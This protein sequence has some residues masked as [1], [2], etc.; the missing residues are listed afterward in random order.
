MMNL[1][2]RLWGMALT[3]KEEI[4]SDGW[5]LEELVYLYIP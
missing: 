1:V 3:I 4:R 5:L 2:K